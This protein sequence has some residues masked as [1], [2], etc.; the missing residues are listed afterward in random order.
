MAGRGFA[1]CCVLSYERPLFVRDAIESLLADPGAPLELIVHDDG[2]ESRE[3]RDYLG[4][5]LDCGQ[6]STVILNPPGHNQGVGEAIRRCFAVAQGD[7]LIKLDQD[8]SF[9]P[10]WLA[11]V[12]QILYDN[13]TCEHEPRI[14][15]LGGFRYSFE[16]VD[17]Q[18]MFRRRHEGWDEVQDFVGSFMAVPRD[19]YERFGPIETHSDAFAE[20][21][22][23][24]LELQA[25]GLALG[26]P[27]D[28][29]VSNHG[30]G[31]G[32]ST[33]NTPEGV[34]SIKK[35]PAIYA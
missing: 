3:L 24:K 19:V 12:N 21:V 22:T 4:N 31:V 20:D 10:G 5:L 18:K 17:H 8:L 30:F 16:P 28:E 23:F 33:V 35:E 25:I 6:A 14:G 32:P 15:A 13:G 27:L 7:P 26:L 29:L 2:S 1:S 11:T 34:R 9:R